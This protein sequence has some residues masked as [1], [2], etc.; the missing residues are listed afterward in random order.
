ML[1]DIGAGRYCVGGPGGHCPDGSSRV[2]V[3]SPLVYSIF[4]LTLEQWRE[5]HVPDAS[6]RHHRCVR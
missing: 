1:N 6:V 5:P 4:P 2:R 3:S